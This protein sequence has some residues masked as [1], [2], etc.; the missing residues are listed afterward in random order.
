VTC[1]QRVAGG[2]RE[3]AQGCQRGEDGDTQRKSDSSD[4]LIFV[5]EGSRWWMA[6]DAYYAAHGDRGQNAGRIRSIIAGVDT[7][8][9]T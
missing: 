8:A 2:A 9:A 7:S 1:S 6:L 4:K 5:K 3:I